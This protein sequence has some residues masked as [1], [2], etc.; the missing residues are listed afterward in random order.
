MKEGEF[1]MKKIFS[2]IIVILISCFVFSSCGFFPS[3]ITNSDDDNNSS[4]E[5][6]G[7]STSV[8]SKEKT[9][10]EQKE[11]KLKDSGYSLSK[12]GD[13]VYY[14]FIVENEDKKTFY[15][16]YK[17]TITALDESGGVLGTEEQT[18]GTIAP[19]ETQAFGSSF[20]VSG[21]K[22]KKVEFE[23]DSGDSKTNADSYI[24]SSN[25]EITQPRDIK[26][27]YDEINFTGKV[28]NNADSD[29]ES[30]AI[31]VIL[32]NKGK[33]VYGDTT[34]VDNVKSSK[35]KAFE[36]GEYDVPEYDSFEVY[37]LDWSF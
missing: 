33:T 28:K 19:G 7:T 32:K 4:S 26:D 24:N 8:V 37:A 23:M 14:A 1:K 36:L 6:N 31:T 18:M 29:C 9:T 25:F 13:Y 22:V 21:G 17:V 5:N 30:I 2:L 20:S 15:E 11:V 10:V 12:D 16:F 35:E 34:Y 27:D 3:A